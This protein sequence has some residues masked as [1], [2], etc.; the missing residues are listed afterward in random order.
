MDDLNCIH[1]ESGLC[2]N[3]RADYEEDPGAW[4]EFGRNPQ[5]IA[6]WQ[7]LQEEIAADQARMVQ[8]MDMTDVPF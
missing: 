3:C 6:N 4:L 7:A 8:P 1:A 5:G 2:P